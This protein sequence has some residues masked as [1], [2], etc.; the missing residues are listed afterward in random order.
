[1]PPP[2]FPSLPPWQIPSAPE[3]REE[4]R[5]GLPD[6]GVDVWKEGEFLIFDDSFEQEIW[7]VNPTLPHGAVD[8]SKAVFLLSVD[9]WHPNLE[10]S[11]RDTLGPLPF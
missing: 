11:A 1:M 3:T 2:S 10:Q 5:V 7:V 4:L 8:P 6:S 9:V